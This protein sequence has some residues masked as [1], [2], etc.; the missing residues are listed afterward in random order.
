VALA[1]A[2]AVAR[3]V[4][5]ILGGAAADPYAANGFEPDL[6]ADFA[7]TLNSGT[8]FYRKQGATT[9]L[10]AFSFPERSGLAT[11]VNASGEL[12]WNAH[13]ILARSDL[14][15]GLSSI[16]VSVV[17]GATS[18]PYGG[19]DAVEIR[20]STGAGEH[21]AFT[22]V[23]SQLRSTHAVWIKPNGRDWA[24]M[25]KPGSTV[26]NTYFNVSTGVV[27]T[28]G[29]GVTATIE[30]G[31]NGWY[32]CTVKADTAVSG[33]RWTV[34]A[35]SADGVKSYTGDG[36]SGIFAWGGS[37]RRE[38]LGGMDDV[39]ASYRTAGAPA[40]YLATT[41][42][43]RYLP[44]FGNH[45]W[46]GSAWVPA[47][48]LVEREAR[49]NVCLDSR[50][51]DSGNWTSSAS[52]VADQTGIDGEANTAFTLTDS[53]GGLEHSRQ[54]VTI[55]DDSNPLVV[56]AFVK[57]TSSASTFPGINV[58]ISGGTSVDGAVTI[59][60]DNG[61]LTDRSSK[62]PTNS[63]IENW[64]PTYWRV[65][66]V[67]TNNG[68]GNT[69][70]TFYLHPAVNSDASGTWSAAATGSAVF[71]QVDVNLNASVP[72]SPIIT[73]GTATARTAD[74]PLTFAAADA[75]YSASG[76]SLAVIGDVDYA[77]EGSA[78]QL[79]IAE[80]ET[81]A[82]NYLSI[83]VDTDSTATGEVN[84][85]QA[86]AGT[87]DT[88]TGATELTPGVAVAFGIASRHTDGAIQVATL[89]S[90]GTANTT[91][92]ALADLSSTNLD[93]ASTGFMGNIARVVGWAED[94]GEAGISQ[95]STED[96]TA[97]GV[98]A[99]GGTITD[100][101]GYRY[102]TF[103]ADGT[104]TVT[105]GGDVEYLIVAGGGGGGGARSGSSTGGGGGGAGG[106]LT[107]SATLTAQGYSITV[108]A[109]G[110]GGTGGLSETNGFAGSDSAFNGNTAT[111]GGGGGK[112]SAGGNT[113]GSGGS[114][115]GSGWQSDA[116]GSGTAGQGN[117]GGHSS[118]ANI[119]VGSG[120]GG[121]KGAAGSDGNDTSNYNGGAGGAGAEWPFGS[122]DNYAG[123]GG[124]GSLSPGSPG[125]GGTGG[126]GSGGAITGDGT[127]VPGTANTGGGGG[128]GSRASGTGYAG[129]DGGSG[130]VVVRYAI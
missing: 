36:T 92:T 37:I 128:G 48:V 7:G 116:S 74:Q 49:T 1:V 33:E 27:G 9:N 112:G 97:P 41:G 2:Q 19:G 109:G 44:R 69:T 60:T 53:G 55:P 110:S 56:T 22:A 23:I 90:A 113:G 5:S 3:P 57:K 71:D 43:A 24:W 61:S 111:G 59:N 114:G 51:F 50:E 106:M 84:A 124:A 102:H 18:A 17:T 91:P 130:V 39:E 45:K 108:G 21:F 52:V 76:L 120:G 78:A 54:S 99:T 25:R 6:A 30:A 129:G 117:D 67:M 118:S 16:G 122:G 66:V 65:S 121:G 42:T 20:E 26:E 38:D 126:G 14:S 88:A 47:G 63:Y 13:N 105:K 95:S 119:N 58:L 104:L 85:N 100:A 93:I 87:V 64:S 15:S 101:G 81:D 28:T 46:N 29:S 62:A 127:G 73:T 123:G 107:G 75:P 4:T 80:R 86:A 31:P 82:N 79:T 103:T 11:L 125:S 96:N 68:T 77:D 34:G 115:G 8:P 35:A 98:I 70:A 32:L 83:D 72:A 12:V 40:N 89:G 94:V 10:A